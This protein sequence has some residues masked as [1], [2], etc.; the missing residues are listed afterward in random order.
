MTE[1]KFHKDRFEVISK[2]KQNQVLEA[3]IHEF[4]ANG[5]NGTNINKVAKR[6]KISIGAMYSYFETKDDLFL[7]VVDYL[8]NVLKRVLSE[9]DFQQDIYKIIESL[10]YKAH[11]YAVKYPEMNQIYL[12]FSTH[13]LS[14]LSNRVSKDLESVSQ[15]IYHQ[16]I[17]DAKSKHLVDEQIHTGILSFLIDNLIMMYQFSY[18]SAYYKERMKIF[19]GELHEDHHIQ[20]EAIMYV[21][22]KAMKPE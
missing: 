12:D 14:N 16:V 8:Q 21:I 22:K 17:E 13:S 10:F 9:V 7:T 11:D 4:A 20:I 15:K 19:I 3:A 6:A 2:E 5:F 1:K 18:T